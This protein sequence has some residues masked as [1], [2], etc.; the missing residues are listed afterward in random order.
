MYDMASKIQPQPEPKKPRKARAV[1]LAD[2][3][4]AEVQRIADRDG[5]NWSEA[6]RRMLKYAALNMPKGWH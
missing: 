6:A 3:G 1:R 2:N 4:E 5:L